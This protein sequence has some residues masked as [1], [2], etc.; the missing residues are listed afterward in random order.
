VNLSERLWQVQGEKVSGS[1][2]VEARRG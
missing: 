2:K 1:W